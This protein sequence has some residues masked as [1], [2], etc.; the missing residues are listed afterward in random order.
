[1]SFWKWAAVVVGILVVAWAA[2]YFAARRHFAVVEKECWQNLGLICKNG[3]FQ[4]LDQ[5]G[6]GC[7]IDFANGNWITVFYRDHQKA[8]LVWEPEDFALALSSDGR[9]FHSRYHLCGYEGMRGQL[10]N[11]KEY[12]NLDD[13]LAKTACCQWRELSSKSD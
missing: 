8:F 3:Q 13:F 9:R 12:T 1:M 11:D 6:L 10:K 5:T 2:G 7:R 4:S